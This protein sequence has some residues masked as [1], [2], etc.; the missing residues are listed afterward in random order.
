MVPAATQICFDDYHPEIFRLQAMRGAQI[1]FYMSWESDVSLEYKLGLDGTGSQQGVVPTRAATNQLWVV[2]ANAGALVDT[3]IT[4]TTSPRGGGGSH[5]QSRVVDPK[6][7]VL[8]Q[9]RIFGLFGA[10][11][12][13]GLCPRIVG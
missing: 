4:E 2:Q 8:E 6:G 11:A 12:P 7:R 10:G 5:G 9:A 1:M 13:S 3:M